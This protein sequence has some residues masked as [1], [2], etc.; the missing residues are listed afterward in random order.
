M[1]CRKNRSPTLFVRA[2]ITQTKPVKELI[3]QVHQSQLAD[4][5]SRSQTSREGFVKAS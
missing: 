1:C 4:I 3:S 5:L 2:A